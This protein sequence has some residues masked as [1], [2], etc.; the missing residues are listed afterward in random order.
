VDIALE[1][2]VTLFD[3]ADVCSQGASEE[4]LGK[5]VAGRRDELLLAMDFVGSGFTRSK[6]DPGILISQDG[7]RQYRPPSYKPNL[8][9]R[10]ANFE[11]RFEP[12]GRFNA[13]GHLDVVP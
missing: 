11:R 2:G 9:R 12:G 6:R 10:Q 1:A 4:I 8:G 5:V 7:L 3:T 13:N